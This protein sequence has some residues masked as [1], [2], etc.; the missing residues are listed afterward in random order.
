MALGKNESLPCKIYAVSFTEFIKNSSY[1][2]ICAAFFLYDFIP[3]QHHWFVYNEKMT[4]EDVTKAV[5][6]LAL[7]FGDDDADPG[8]MVSRSS[9]LM[10]RISFTKT[11]YKISHLRIRYMVHGDKVD[12]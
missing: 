4:V 12:H 9:F 2:S 11:I 10:L 1:L 8:A 3:L 5:S 7:A 6:N